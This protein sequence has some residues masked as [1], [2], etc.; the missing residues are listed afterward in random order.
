MNN[1][2]IEIILDDINHESVW[3]ALKDIIKNIYLSDEL[4]NEIIYYSNEFNRL[5]KLR[6]FNEIHNTINAF[7]IKNIDEIITNMFIYSNRTDIYKLYIRVLKRWSKIH[8]DFI[9]YTNGL[10]YSLFMSALNYIKIYDN[11]YD[12]IIEKLRNYFIKCKN[13]NKFK[14]GCLNLNEYNL[15]L[16]ELKDLTELSLKHRCTSILNAIYEYSDIDMIY[17]HKPEF[18]NNK[19][20]IIKGD[21][22]YN[23]IEN[24]YL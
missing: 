23:Y 18:K 20:K 16:N 7:L 4:N 2:D 12:F 15:I 11:R 24:K 5:Q 22:I 17:Y 10:T 13:L 8:K 1:K 6:E 14:I 21:K 19:Y 9:M 3:L